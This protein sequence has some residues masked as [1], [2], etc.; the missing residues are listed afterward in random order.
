M[1]KA[2][3]IMSAIALSLGVVACGNKKGDNQ[4]QPNKDT[5]MQISKKQQVVEL[6]K[7]IET[8]ASEPVGCINANNYKQHNLG[9]ADWFGRFR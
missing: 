8:G 9:I 5:T 3:I 7:A 4:E 1:K 2:F 6:L